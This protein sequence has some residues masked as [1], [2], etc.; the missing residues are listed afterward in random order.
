MDRGDIYIIVEKA[1]TVEQ[2][3]KFLRRFLGH[4]G[5]RHW[6]GAHV[7]DI[8]SALA[9][10]DD[11]IEIVDPMIDKIITMTAERW[12][13]KRRALLGSAIRALY[14]IDGSQ[15][16]ER[17]I[18]FV[19]RAY[20]LFLPTLDDALRAL[21]IERGWGI[22]P[23]AKENASGELH[24]FIHPETKQRMAWLDALLAEGTRDDKLR[25][26]G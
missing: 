9:E 12:N 13:S 21:L 6:R 24:E 14:L 22:D 11:M 2:K 7:A 20:R 16:P 10:T 25:K 1:L 26:E 8:L 19:D 18:K 5:N 4:P 3:D 23:T 15:D 17:I